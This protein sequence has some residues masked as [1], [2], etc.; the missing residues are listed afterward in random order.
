LI[1]KITQINTQPG[2]PYISVGAMR[3]GKKMGHKQ[4]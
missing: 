2:H 4:A 3:K 1:I